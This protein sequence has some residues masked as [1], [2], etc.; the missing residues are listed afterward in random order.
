MYYKNV[1]H[2]GKMFHWKIRI[3]ANTLYSHLCKQCYCMQVY[4]KS[5]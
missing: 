1:E 4:K 3:C 2:N 5:V